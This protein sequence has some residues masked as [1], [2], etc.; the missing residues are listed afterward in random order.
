MGIETLIVSNSEISLVNEIAEGLHVNFDNLDDTTVKILDAAKTTSF[1]CVIATDDRTVEI[2]SSVAEQLQLP[3][4]PP[5]AT[6]VSRWKHLARQC[7]L[8]AGLPVPVFKCLNTKIDILEQVKG[9]PLPCVVKPLNLSASRGVIRAN[10]TDE[11]ITAIERVRAIIADQSEVEARQQLLLEQYIPG[12]EVALEGM[13]SKGRFVPLAVFDK[14][15]PLEGP[16]FEETYY[17]TPSR[18]SN[19]VQNRLIEIT[20][21]ACK[22]MGLVTG[23]VH[24]ELRIDGEDIRILEIAA[25][26]I[27]GECAKLLEYTT[28]VSLETLVIGNA[29]GQTIELQ[30]AQSSA[31]VL[32]IPTPKAGILRR[33]EGVL[34]ARKIQFVNDVFI[35]V[36]EGHELK[37]LPEASGYLGYIFASADSPEQVENA[38]RKAHD[39]LNI[40]VAPFWKLNEID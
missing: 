19:T 8:D 21:D 30:Q 40:V 16:C 35:A 3:N 26:T 11:L 17:I 4:N 25:R 34:Q 2:A 33:V 6:R 23:P 39:C 37:T 36:R 38:L 5:H 31:G 1:S 12:V 9:F 29:T 24:A 22:A 15:D 7:L 14:P 10:T 27:G 20:A 13:L 28:G 32:M 18:L